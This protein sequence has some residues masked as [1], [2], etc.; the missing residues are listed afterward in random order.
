MRRTTRVEL[1][2]GCAGL[3]LPDG[4]VLRPRSPGGAVD[5]P[6]H[7]ADPRMVRALGAAP[8]AYALGGPMGP[9]GIVCECGFHRFAWTDRPLSVC[10]RCGRAE[11]LEAT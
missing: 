9:A 1:P 2:P 5:V 7:L 6:G 11:A 8:P 10:P 4:S 3:D